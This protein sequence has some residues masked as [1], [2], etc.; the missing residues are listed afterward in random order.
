MLSYLLEKFNAYWYPKK[1]IFGKLG[2]PFS[3]KDEK[4]LYRSSLI[5]GPSQCGKTSFY[6]GYLKG[7]TD[8]LYFPLKNIKT[9]RDVCERFK[10]SSGS[11]HDNS[12][13]IIKE[14][15]NAIDERRVVTK[16]SRLK[17]FIVVDDLQDAIIPEGQDVN[18]LPEI[19]FIMGN[20][21]DLAFSRE[22]AVVAYLTNSEKTE[23]AFRKQ[24]GHNSR[25][26]IANFDD[27]R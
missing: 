23:R 1:G 14:L 22:K 9:D 4:T 8:V 21:L 3:Y 19:R 7:K 27:D 6:L 10:E 13:V 5:Y 26:F 2:L 15:E 18:F 24:S 11:N 25:F 16:N 12:F 17:I 20:F